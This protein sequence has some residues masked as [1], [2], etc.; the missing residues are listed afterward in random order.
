MFVFLLPYEFHFKW[1]SREPGDHEMP[2][3]FAVLFVVNPTE[4]PRNGID[5]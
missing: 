3:A 1:N 2:I 4:M 5:K